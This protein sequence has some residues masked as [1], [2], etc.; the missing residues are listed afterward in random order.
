MCSIPGLPT[1]GSEVAVLVTR[2]NLNPSNGLVELWVNLDDERKHIYEQMREKIQ[3]PKRNFNR[4]EGQPGDLCLVYIND[5]WHRARIV[6]IQSETY[7]VFLIDQGQSHIATG[8][9]LAWGQSD[10]FL[11]PPEIESCVLANVLSLENNWPEKATTFLMSLPGKKFKGL[12]QH[13]LM[14]DRIILLDIPIVSKHMCKYRV[15]KKIP[16]EEFKCLVEN[17]LKSPKG[18]ASEAQYFYPELLT[19]AFEM[20]SVTEVMN[21]LNIFCQLQIFSKA[22]K[23]LSEQV[24]QRYEESSDYGGAQPQ[25]CGTPC[26][27]RGTNGRWH[28]SLLKQ[29]I[30]TSDGVVEVLH[31]DEGKTESVPVGDIR[32][33]LGEFLRMPVFTYLCSLNGVKEDAKKWTAEETDYLK[34]LLLNKTVVTWFDHQNKGVYRATFYGA[35]ATCIND[36]FIEKAGII[37]SSPEQDLN[38]QTEPIS[39]SLLSTLGDTDRCVQKTVTKNDGLPDQTGSVSKNRVLSGRTDDASSSGTLTHNNACLDFPPEVQSGCDNSAFTVGSSVDVKISCIES[40]QKFWC[41]ITDSSDALKRLMKELQTHYSFAYPQPIVESICVARNP[42]NGTWYRAKIMANQHSPVVNVRFIDYGETRKVPLQD[43]RPIDPAFLRLSAQAFQCCLFNLMDPTRTNHALPEFQKFVDSGA[44]SNT[45]L[46]CIVKG[47]TSDE[48]GLLLNMVDIET[49][50]DSACKLLAQKCAHPPGPSDAFN[51]S[52]YDIKIGGREK[53]WVT[54]SE[55]VNNFYCQLERN[56]DMFDKMM[57]NVVQLLREQTPRR[58]DNLLGNNSIC[59]ARYTDNQ[60]Y[61]GQVVKMSPEIKVHFVDHGDTLVVSETDIQPVPSEA[62]VAR[63]VPVQAVPLGLFNIPTDVPQEVNQWFEENAVGCNFT[64]LVVEKRE[65]GKLFVE[66]FEESLNINVKVREKIAEIKSKMSLSSSSKQAHVSKA[67]CL[68]Q[69]L[70][71]ASTTEQNAVR[72]RMVRDELQMSSKSSADVSA[73]LDGHVKVLD[74]ERKPTLSVKVTVAETSIHSCHSDSEVIELSVPSCPKGNVNICQFKTPNISQNQTHEVYASSI[75]GPHYFWCQYANSDILNTLLKLTQEAGQAQQHAI[76]GEP[77]EPGSPC[78]AL[79]VSDNQWYRAQVIQKAGNKLNVLFVDYGNES[80]VDVEHV[81]SLPQSLVAFVPQAF[82]CSLSGFEELK[83]S[84]DD[85]VHDDFYNLLVDKPF[86]VTILNME[87]H[88]EIAVPQYTVRA[89]CDELV[90]NELMQ[91]Y[92]KSLSAEHSK[93]EMTQSETIPKVIQTTGNITQFDVSKENN[94]TS[95]YKNPEITVNTTEMVYAS[96]VAEPHYF[97]CQCTNTADLEA[98]TQLAQEAGQEQ[99]DTVLPETL[100]PGSPCL[101]LFSSDSQWYRA[102]VIRKAGNTAEV[103][104]VDYG[105][106]SEVNI[107]DLRSLPQSLLEKAPQG[108]LCCL[109]GFDES[110]GCWE[111]EAYEEFHN[112]LVDKPLKLTVCSMKAHPEIA[113]PQYSVEIDCEGVVVNTLMEKYWKAEDTGM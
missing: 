38:D 63:H 31:V 108:F 48:D 89:E 37:L 52:T 83:G 81:R 32:P 40:L 84:W 112:L 76:F 29:N 73:L 102:L 60:W 6:S 58:P 88:S 9:T 24:H 18:E 79:F 20:V 22:V 77:L 74:E 98:V 53:V 4:L 65:D 104:F 27:A 111:D 66:L 33:L 16:S 13:V 85:K 21:P 25:R 50:S 87:N 101:A 49:A 110:K 82:L 92:W 107:K 69:K 100:G 93:N 71:K 1:P 19:E 95:T 72:D 56:S 15:A 94:N 75:V 36:S 41:Q 70:V 12:V 55:S 113:L 47:V 26:A 35:K 51:Y 57:K 64:I 109:K 54:S 61:R 46:K 14:S 59:F 45:G 7:N 90:I 28:R 11:L 2:V 105:N 80:E 30:V 97:W 39:S 96:S 8:E 5:A 68:T 17:C 67:R 3:I 91:K 103:L 106:E 34:S 78:L 62:S 10:S 99:Q 43:V 44:S 23:L 42:D 86:K